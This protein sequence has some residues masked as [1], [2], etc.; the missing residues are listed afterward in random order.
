MAIRPQFYP[1]LKPALVSAV[2]S[3]GIGHNGGP[4]YD[5]DAQAYIAATGEMF[6]DALNDLVLGIKAAGLWDDHIGSIKK[7][8]GVPSLA[9]SMIDLRNTAFNGTAVNTPGHSATAGWGFTAASSQYIDS[10]W[11]V[12]A[13]G[14]KASQNSVHFGVRCMVGGV[15][16]FPAASA[17]NPAFLGFASFLNGTQ[18]FLLNDTSSL[19]STENPV[20]PGHYIG[21]RRGP[22]ER[23]SYKNGT[24]LA[25]DAVASF[26]TVSVNL[27]IGARNFTGAP[28]N[29]FT[30]R[31]SIFHAGAGL[32]DTQAAALTTLFDAYA[33]AAGEA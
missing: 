1:T 13:T 22:T 23:E 31:I 17:A 33:T 28:D 4:S 6:P 2:G 24:S 16:G 11:R 20:A 14:S 10:A 9:A 27:F 26:G 30:G 32:D 8:I 5:P 12:P 18:W 29:Y 21:V 15:A 19:S 25:S 3:F 7:A